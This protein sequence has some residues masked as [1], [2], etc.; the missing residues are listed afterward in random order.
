MTSQWDPGNFKPLDMR[1]ILGYPRQ[2]PPRY[3][4][5][6]PRF[7]GSD[8][9][10]VEDHMSDFWAFFHLHPINDDV[11]DLAMKIFST[12]L[13]DDA[14]RW[15]DD[16]PNA[17]ITYMDQLEE[18]FLRILNVKEDP[19]MLL[20]ILVHI[21]NVE[22]EAIKDLHT[23][24][25]RMSQQLPRR[26][27]HVSEFFLVMY[28]RAFSGQ[29]KFILD[30]RS[31]RTIQEAYDMA[32][33]VEANISSSKVERLFSPQVKIDDPKGTLETLSLERIMSLEIS[34]RW[35]RD[36]DPQ[37]AEERDPDEGYQSHDEEQEFT[38]DSIKEDLVEG[39]ELEEREILICASP[40]NEAI[41]GPIPLAQDK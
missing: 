12:A 37:K 29:S 5:W 35:E 28:I 39:Q 36:I 22:N 31:P 27:R 25:R 30:T 16:L 33:E 17:S 40:S 1:K 10:N 19:D 11:K 26:H 21:K 32:M 9:E 34:E 13:C 7:T 18:V 14:R 6:H 8:E 23:K 41:R 20:Q 24:F 15:Y 4:K 38:H 3:E 2:M